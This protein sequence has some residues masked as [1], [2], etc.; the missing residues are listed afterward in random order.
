MRQQHRETTDAMLKE[1]AE[2]LAGVEAERTK[3]L[4][5]VLEAEAEAERQRYMSRL[6]HSQPVSSSPE[7]ERV[8][9]ESLV[10]VLPLSILTN[11][12]GQP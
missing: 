10:R 2:R 6:G 3:L 5:R 12:G 8:L 1:G 9:R 11:G 4:S 7:I